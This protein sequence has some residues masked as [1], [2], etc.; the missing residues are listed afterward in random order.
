MS[1]TDTTG[2]RHRDADEIGRTA[3][4]P[5]DVPGLGEQRAAADLAHT[6]TVLPNGLRVL[7]VRKQT[8]PMVEMRLTIP[9]AGDDPRHPATAEV[10]A[11]TLL[12]GTR[13]RDRVAIDTDLAL[14]GGELGPMVDPEHLGLSGS[15]LASGL[16]T[17]LDVLADV[18]TEASHPDAEVAREADRIAER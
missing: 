5:R 2:P 11:E 7:A 17:L 4:G 9:F 13:R 1:A 8:V 16:P 12:T 15:A 18:L 10:L 3:T 6:D 14:I